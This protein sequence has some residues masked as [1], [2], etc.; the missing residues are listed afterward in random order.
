MSKLD[1]LDLYTKLCGFKLVVCANRLKCDTRFAR[2]VHDRLIDALG[3]HIDTCRQTLRLEHLLSLEADPVARE[4]LDDKIYDCLGDLGE[5]GW[6]FYPWHLLDSV[7]TDPDFGGYIYPAAAMWFPGGIPEAMVVGDEHLCGLRT[8]I[9]QIATE[10]GIRFTAYLCDAR[11]GS[12]GAGA[13]DPAIY[14]TPI[15]NYRYR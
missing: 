9:D 11:I 4:A 1:I 10:T 15:G 2:V 5:G 12:Q 13:L 3:S 14:E 8:I 7:D 6:G